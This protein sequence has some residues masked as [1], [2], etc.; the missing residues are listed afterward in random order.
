MKSLEEGVEKQEQPEENH[1][2]EE[3]PKRGSDKRKEQP[4]RGSDKNRNSQGEEVNGYGTAIKK[5]NSKI[6][7]K[8]NRDEGKAVEVNVKRVEKQ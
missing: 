3:F 5:K 6:K 7:F 8:T 2:M 1:H 4:E